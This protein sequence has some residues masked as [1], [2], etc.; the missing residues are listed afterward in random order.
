VPITFYLYAGYLTLAS[1]Y[2][3][4]AVLLGQGVPRLLFFTALGF[5]A[6]YMNARWPRH[7][8]TRAVTAATLFGNTIL[9]SY[10]GYASLNFLALGVYLSGGTLLAV[11]AAGFLMGLALLVHT[12]LG[13]PRRG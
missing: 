7:Y 8:W 13:T 12:L 9:F 10:Q 4:V 5:T 3:A 1:L 11:S 2:W 6:L